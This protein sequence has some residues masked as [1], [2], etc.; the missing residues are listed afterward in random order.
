MPGILPAANRGREGE[1]RC[2]AG[3]PRSIEELFD[4]VMRAL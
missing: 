3:H 1:L 4:R 2:V